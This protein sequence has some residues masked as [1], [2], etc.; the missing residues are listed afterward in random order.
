MLV[1]GW[2]E[3][4]FISLSL[5]FFEPFKGLVV[6]KKLNSR[7]IKCKAD[8]YGTALRRQETGNFL[9]RDLAYP[10]ISAASIYV[11]ECVAGVGGGGVWEGKGGRGVEKKHHQAT[12]SGPGTVFY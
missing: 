5:P 4:A 11:Q 10:T 3:G 7:R 12:L 9:I 8:S 6:S 1:S 2:V